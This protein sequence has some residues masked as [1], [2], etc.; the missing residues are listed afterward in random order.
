MIGIRADAND[1][2]ASGHIMRCIAIALRLK[3]M[4]VETQFYIS[5]TY[6][7]PLLE[8]RGLK[9]RVLCNDWRNKEEETELLKSLVRTDNVGVLLVDSYEVRPQYFEKLHPYVKIA[10]MDDMCGAPYDVDMIVNY[11]VC[12]CDMRYNAFNWKKKPLMLTGLS[13]TPLREEFS[14]V[15][16]EWTDNVSDI[17]I[18]TGGTDA[19]EITCE[20]TLKLS[21]VLSDS[22][23][24]HVVEGPFFAESTR[25]KLYDFERIKHNVT[26]H[27]DVKR[28]DE[29]LKEC[30]LAVSAG[31]TTLLE[32]CACR[33]P[34]V[35]FAISDN[36]KALVEF[37]SGQKAVSA[38]M[39]DEIAEIVAEVKEL[40]HN[41]IK[42][43]QIAKKA[44]CLVDGNGAGR[45]A[46]ALIQI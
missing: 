29:L 21:E 34:C 31:G 40:C 17:L 41:H 4:G 12:D 1:V 36:Q 2:I 19:K 15:S 27:R 39:A 44:G 46:E 32:I 35:C 24:L 10:Y 28:M 3:T 26:V 6:S 5:D 23:K 9:Y 30:Q 33:V 11:A 20:I 7:V 25:N 8:S 45:I 18:T 22:I 42:R 37:L 16:C 38:F 13:Y 43:R 14:D